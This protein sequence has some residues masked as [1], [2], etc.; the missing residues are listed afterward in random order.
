VQ[1]GLA[2]QV[3]VMKAFVPMTTPLWT[4]RRLAASLAGTAL[5]SVAACST[6]PPR[7]RS[8]RWIELYNLHTEEHINVVFADERG[9]RDDGLR[10]LE[11]F[12]RDFR[13]RETH[14]IDPQ[15]YV[16]LTDLADNARVLPRFEVISGY[17]SPDTN[18]KLHEGGHHVALH[19]EH[20]RGKAID[21]RL[22]GCS[23]RKLRDLA[24]AAA[25]G[26]VGYYPRDEFVHI[27]TGPIRSWVG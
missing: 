26:G 13:Q 2:A 8:T 1:V 18:E 16:L 7:P 11:F 10:K 22:R 5:L 21:V 9:F 12:L 24:L 27:D 23:V 15:L 19:S 3:A 17:R 20:M 14:R 4:R 25:R 6:L